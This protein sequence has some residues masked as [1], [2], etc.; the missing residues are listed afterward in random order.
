MTTPRNTVL[1][2]NETVWDPVDRNYVSPES[3]E[4]SVRKGLTRRLKGV[5]E[6]LSSVEFEALV[7]KMTRE[8]LR[9]EGITGRH[10]RP[11]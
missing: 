8:Q 4:D 3:R 9:G 7:L 6:E 2:V 11:F 10:V 1:G 5:C